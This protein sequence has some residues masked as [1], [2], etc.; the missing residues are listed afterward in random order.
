MFCQMAKRLDLEASSG[1]DLVYTLDV[2]KEGLFSFLNSLTMILQDTSRGLRPPKEKVTSEA[3]RCLAYIG[4][5]YS[6]G[7]RKMTRILAEI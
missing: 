3:S 1:K 5:S 2:F 7:P 6:S 4:D